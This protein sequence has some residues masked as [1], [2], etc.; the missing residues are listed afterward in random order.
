MEDGKL[1]QP[2]VKTHVQ[3]RILQWLW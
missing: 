3:G 1:S 2:A